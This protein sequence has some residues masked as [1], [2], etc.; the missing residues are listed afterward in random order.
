LTE[1]PLSRRYATKAGNREIEANAAQAVLAARLDSLLAQLGGRRPRV[2]FSWRS[3]TSTPVKGLY[4]YG[5]VGRGKTMLM[6]WF[7]DAATVERKR[8][9]HF[10]EFMGDVQ[11]RIHLARRSAAADPIAEVAAAIADE[12]QLLC[13]DEFF[14]ADIADAMI[15]SRLF[16]RLF[17]SGLTLVTTSN[18]APEDLYKDGLNRNLFLPFIDVLKRNADVFFLDVDTDYRLTK[19]AGTPVYLTPLG[20]AARASLDATWRRLT[21][22]EKGAPATLTNYGRTI[23]VPE[24]AEGVAR[25]PFDALCRAPLA[26]SD[27]LVIARAYHTIMIDDVPVLSDAERDVA[28]RLILLVD[29]L[30]D[31]GA[32]LIVSAAAEP[33]DLYTATRGE[34]A[35]SFPRTVSRLIEMRSEAYLAAPPRRPKIK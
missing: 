21:G 15:L 34:E 2:L 25:F 17:D 8:R 14:V 10:N 12:T 6:D 19:L 31:R 20:R 33:G 24:T 13:L 35:A 3:R 30:Y 1:G 11:D 26:A 32:R 18:T 22:S 16:D 9:T 5:S 7:F 23:H 28:R 4:I 27:Y 29:T